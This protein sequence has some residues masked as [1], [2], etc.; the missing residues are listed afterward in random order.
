MNN[1]LYIWLVLTA[2]AV[3]WYSSVTIYVA[4]KGA[5]DIKTMLRR[6]AELKSQE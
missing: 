4:I 2:A 6:L 3:I 5:L 1:W